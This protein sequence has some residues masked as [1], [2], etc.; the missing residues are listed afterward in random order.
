M[1]TYKKKILFADCDPGGIMFFANY[2]KS[3]HEAF[4]NFMASENYFDDYFKNKNFA[5]LLINAEA[6]YHLPLQAGNEITIELSV[7]KIRESSFEIFYEFKLNKKLAAK[8]NTVHVCIDVK[9]LKKTKLPESL[10]EI[11]TKHLRA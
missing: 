11:L 8:G 6:K 10:R 1:F 4:E 7:T 9:N 5:Y 2:F 3:M